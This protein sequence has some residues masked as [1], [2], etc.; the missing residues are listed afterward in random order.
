MATVLRFRAAAG[1]AGAFLAGVSLLSR[2]AP[3]GQPA[4]QEDSFRFKTGVELINVTAT[5]TDRSGRFV[6][7][8]RQEDFVVYEDNELQTVTHFGAERGP[9]SLGI[10]L[11]TSDSMEGEKIQ[12]AKATL[13][14][15]FDELL[16]ERD[17]LFLY[18]F[19]DSP[20][21]LQDWTSDRRLLSR[22]L[23]RANPDGA[24]AMYDAVAEAVPFAETGGNLKKALVLI[25]DGNDTSSHTAIYDLKQIVRE[26]EVLVYAI[27]I[28]AERRL[29]VRPQPIP[30]RPQRVPIPMPFP[31]IRWPGRLQISVPGWPGTWNG[32][33]RVN[34]AAL[35]DLT[36]DS[37]SRTEIIRSGRDLDPATSSIANELSQQYYLGYP[38]G[39]KKDGRW[40][41]IKLELRNCAYW[42][43]ARRGYIASAD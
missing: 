22:A 34:V 13:R 30:R 19:N 39:E 41:A 3:A 12:A 33:E 16:D 15:F 2:Q 28:D 27:G 36:D 37:G 42:V 40:H 17:E 21:L 18:R 4:D 14:R 25:S 26:S 5:V 29:R 24:T 7:G 20:A 6:P 11:D 32:N 35:R 9:V 38:T 23:N 43:R 1:V 10:V 8:L 31:P